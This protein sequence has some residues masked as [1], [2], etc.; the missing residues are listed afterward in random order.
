M[1]FEQD[2]FDIR[3]EWASEGLNNISQKCRAIVIVDV[4]SFCTA[5]DIG[6][7]QCEFTISNVPFFDEI[8][9][10]LDRS[11]IKSAIPAS[12]DRAS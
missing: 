2:G 12:I 10:P 8:N 7:N 11:T 4:L 6:V 9:V 3:C 1:F 5:V